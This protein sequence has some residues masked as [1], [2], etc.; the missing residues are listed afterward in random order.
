M[1]LFQLAVLCLSIIFSVVLTAHFKYRLANQLA[2][3]FRN[4]L[5][6]GDTR[7][8]ML[9]L[10]RTIHGDFVGVKW[11]PNGLSQAFSIPENVNFT[12]TLIYNLHSAYRG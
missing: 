6:M 2:A 12:A 4:D 3:A 1:L 8:A 10:P 7:K 5:L 9:E 11:I